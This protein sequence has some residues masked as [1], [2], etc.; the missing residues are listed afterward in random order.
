MFREAMRSL[1]MEKPFDKITVKEITE[2]AGLR[3]ATFYLHYQT[4]EDLLRSVLNVTFR[5]LVERSRALAHLDV[6]GGKT[7][8]DAYL[9]TFEHVAENAALYQRL[10]AGSGGALAY[11]EIRQHLADLVLE[12][13]G[14]LNDETMDMPPTVIA[15]YIAGTELSLIVWWLNAGMPYTT[16]QMAEMTHRLVLQGVMS[17]L[18]EQSS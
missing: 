4:K 2:R 13:L 10:L 14:A 7:Q 3:R 18:S 16:Q 1:V 6:I 9:V 12:G 17:V 8:L 15:Q 11:E 5:S